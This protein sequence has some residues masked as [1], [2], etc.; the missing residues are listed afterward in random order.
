[1]VTVDALLATDD[2]AAV[3]PVGRVPAVV[4]AEV[5]YH[6]MV[7]A[8]PAAILAVVA[9]NVAL[10]AVPLVIVPDWAPRLTVAGVPPELAGLEHPNITRLIRTTHENRIRLLD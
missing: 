3:M 9:A 2:A 5:V 4:P 8:V 10:P 7:P 1:M 6:A